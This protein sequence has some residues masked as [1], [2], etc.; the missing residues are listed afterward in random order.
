MSP[1]DAR[2]DQSFKQGTAFRFKRES[3]DQL[4]QQSYFDRI[5]R[6]E[7]DLG[8]VAR[9]ILQNPVAGGLC[10]DPASY[11]LSG[12]LYSHGAMAVGAEAP[13]LREGKEGV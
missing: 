10:D 6:R 12:G 3:G 5:L 8:D 2:I 7:D 1:S 4:W 11:P 9:Y 13:S